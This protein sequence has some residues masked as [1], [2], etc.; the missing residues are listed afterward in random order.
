V[1][2][3]GIFYF[4]SIF[5]K[6]LS[7]FLSVI[8]SMFVWVS[9]AYPAVLNLSY[10]V[11]WEDVKIYRTDNSRWW[12]MA[13]SVQ[14]PKTKD[15]MHFWEVKISDQVFTYTKQWWW[16]QKIW[17]VPD[18]WDEQY[19]CISSSGAPCDI[20]KDTAKTTT[21]TKAT[22]DKTWSVTR[23]VIPV[24]PKTGPSWSLIWIILATLAIFGGYIYIKKRA[25]I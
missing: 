13:I 22:N 15:W 18:E 19:L 17:I 16:D 25:D 4:L 12:Y 7:I 14:E 21:T 5:M 23:T 2:F 11:N 24:V 9:F 3:C 20:S 8:F 10:S 6:K 1:I